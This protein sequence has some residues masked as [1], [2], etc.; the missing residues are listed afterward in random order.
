MYAKAVQQALLIPTEPI[1]E[2]LAAAQQK[3][4]GILKTSTM[5]IYIFS[6]FSITSISVNCLSYV[7]LTSEFGKQ[8]YSQKQFLVIDEKGIEKTSKADGT[9]HPQD[10]PCPNGGVL[11]SSSSFARGPSATLDIRGKSSSGFHHGH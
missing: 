3:Y 5:S 7:F 10:Y 6:W 9:K 8:A 2:G 11:W 4:Q 1:A